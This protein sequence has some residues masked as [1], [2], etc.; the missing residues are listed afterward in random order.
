MPRGPGLG[1]AL[2]GE[3]ALVVLDEPTSA[4]DPVGRVDV[5]GIVRDAADR[6]A[7]VF[8]TS[9]LLSE[10]EQVCDRV[11]IIDHGRVVASGEL[12]AVLGHSETQGRRTG[13]RAGGLPP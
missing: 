12:D 10:V 4:L 13:I 9:H 11:A 5:R 8:L 6:G 1:R 3:P 7:A 2:L